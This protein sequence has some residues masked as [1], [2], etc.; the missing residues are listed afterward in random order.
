MSHLKHVLKIFNREFDDLNTEGRQIIWDCI[1]RRVSELTELGFGIQ[2]HDLVR[3][4]GWEVIINGT[5]KY[6]EK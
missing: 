1:K 5:T 3:A 4:Y 6:E 2:A